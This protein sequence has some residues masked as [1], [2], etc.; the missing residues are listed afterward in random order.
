MIQ[1]LFSVVTNNTDNQT[2]D[3][4]PPVEEADKDVE[5]S[6][7]NDPSRAEG[8]IHFD[9]QNFSKIKD[10]T[11]SDPVTIRNLPWYVS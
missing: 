8:L 10:T 9:V 4:A 6:E 11:L 3:T 7:E 1:I 2:D 5:M